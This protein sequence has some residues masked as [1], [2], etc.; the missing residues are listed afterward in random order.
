M[1]QT[2][3]VCSFCSL[4]P[5]QV[6]YGDNPSLGLHSP[7]G[8][9]SQMAYGQYSPVSTPVPPIMVDNQLFSHQQ[10]PVS[11]QYYPQ[12]V[13]SSMPHMSAAIPVSHAEM[14]TPKGTYLKKASA[15]PPPG[16]KKRKKDGMFST[17]F[18]FVSQGTCL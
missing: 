17:H 5:A 3:H 8:F 13:G 7:Y 12:P 10:I 14:V 6:I 1:V 15:S 9:N 2:N 18:A 4:L 16:P 11:P